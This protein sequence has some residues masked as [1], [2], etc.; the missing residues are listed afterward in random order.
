MPLVSSQP[1][2][3]ALRRF[4]KLTCISTFI[5]IF[6]GGLVKSTESGLSVPDWPTTYGRFM[7]AFPWS[8]MVGGIKYEHTHRLIASIIGLMTLVLC[9]WLYRA[10]VP[11]WIQRLGLCAFI[12]VILQGVLGGLTV[13]YFLP[14]WLSS[15]HGTL[16]HI[17]FLLTLMIAYGLSVEYHARRAVPAIG[18]D[19]KFLRMSMIFTGM[20]FIQLILGNVMRH[21]ESGLAVPDFPTMGGALIPTFNH[22]MLEHINAWRFE[23][24]FDPVTI[25]QVH[26]HILHRVWALLILVKLMYINF[27]AYQRHLHNGLIMKTLFGLNM[28]VGLQIMLGIATVLSMKEVYTT[29]FHVLT[30]ALVLGIN[31]TLVLRSSPVAFGEFQTLLAKR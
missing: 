9:V 15:F 4:S 27:L 24:G 2:S 1:S 19:G 3:V 10:H 6:I 28:A 29:T 21:T 30:G 25:G 11:R 16:A 5:L 23:H 14:V 13:K 31:L 18:L 26:L 8:D 12:T 20:V 17:F 22:T 7:F